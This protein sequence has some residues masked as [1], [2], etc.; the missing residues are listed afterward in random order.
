MD[1]LGLLS[2]NDRHFL[3]LPLAHSF[4]KVLELAVIRTGVPTAVDGSNR[5][6]PANLL[7]F[8]P[9]VMAADL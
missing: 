1:K 7:A 4:A 5:D 3:F 9:T 8:R 6:L 2:P